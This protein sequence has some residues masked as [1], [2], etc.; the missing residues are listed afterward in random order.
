MGRFSLC[1]L[2]HYTPFFTLLNPY[3]FTKKQAVRKQLP[4]NL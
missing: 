4:A 2:I 1:K 3:T